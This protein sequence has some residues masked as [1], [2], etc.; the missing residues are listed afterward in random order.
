MHKR[1]TKAQLRKQLDDEIQNFLEQGG[2]VQELPRGATGLI[3][4]R[5][6]ALGFDRKP[7]A[8]TDVTDV[9]K[10]IDQRREQ[11]RKPKPAK[12]KKTQQPQKKVIYD[13]FGEPIRI[14]WE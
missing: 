1:P 14:V 2:E 11:Q 7:E 6:H 10:T 13:D 4:G 9:L 12:P 5:Y 3:D 8:R